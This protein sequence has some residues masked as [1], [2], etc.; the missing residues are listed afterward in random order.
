MKKEKITV[1]EIKPMEHPRVCSI[2]PTIEAFRKAVRTDIIEYGDVEA[3]RISRDAYALFNKDRFLTGLVP[4]R[5]I[6]DD[7]ICG[8]MYIVAADNKR[9][10]CSLLSTQ[11]DKYTLQFYDIE[12]FD[13]IDVAE[14]NTNTMMSRFRKNEEW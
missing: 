9:R 1:L 11:I 13:D 7:I 6:G 12:H 10:D 3:K 8:T 5:Q 2:E 4:N 14:A